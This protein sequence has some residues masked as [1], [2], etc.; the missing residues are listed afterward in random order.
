MK[1][2]AAGP[3]VARVG[4][5]GTTPHATASRTQAKRSVAGAVGRPR[6]L[7]ERQ[8]RAL[9]G[10]LGAAD[11]RCM[12]W[13]AIAW[14]LCFA[15]CAPDAPLHT[16]TP[17]AGYSPD[18]TLGSGMGAIEGVVVDKDDHKPLAGA[19][20]VI[21]PY[22]DKEQVVVTDDNG[23]FRAVLAPGRYVVALYYLD[24]IFKHEGVVL[25]AGGILR[26][27][28]AFDVGGSASPRE[29]L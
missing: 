19:T 22:L 13:I 5:C 8:Q 14:L 15:A 12:K 7:S 29:E 26:V 28:I 9:D 21:G 4:A 18:P 2:R 3:V 20:I 6:V 24:G 25:R 11:T 16:F 17:V 23:H 27:Q 10:A 1:P